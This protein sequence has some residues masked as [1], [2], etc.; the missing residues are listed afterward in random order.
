MVYAVDII[1]PELADRILLDLAEAY[2]AEGTHR[3]ISEKGTR[4]FPDYL[5]SAAL[6]LGG[7]HKMAMRRRKRLEESS[8]LSEF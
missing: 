4:R 6:P 1:Q 2:V 7:I 3:F 8:M 5:P